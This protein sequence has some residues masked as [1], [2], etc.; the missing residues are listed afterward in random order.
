M[1]TSRSLGEFSTKIFSASANVDL[2]TSQ[3]MRKSLLVVASIV[4]TETPVDTGRARANWQLSIDYDETGEVVKT[5]AGEAESG[6][7]LDAIVQ[8]SGDFNTKRNKVM[9]LNNN[10][11]Y[12]QGLNDGNSVQAPAGFIDEAI[13]SGLHAVGKLDIFKRNI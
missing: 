8:K 6:I 7:A 5:F 2:V 3:I 13:Q 4:T 10:L 11:P 12:I 9:Y 1:G